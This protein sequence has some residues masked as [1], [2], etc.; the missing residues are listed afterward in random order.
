VSKITTWTIE[1]F[2]RAGTV[3]FDVKRNGRAFKYDL[4]DVQ[5]AV[6]A[7]RRSRKFEEGDKLILIDETGYR[8]SLRTI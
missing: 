3:L 1:E 6:R 5:D 2:H 8:S 4:D 7:I